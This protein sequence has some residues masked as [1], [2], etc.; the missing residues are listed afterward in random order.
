MS[1]YQRYHL[2]FW[3]EVVLYTKNNKTKSSQEVANNLS[4]SMSKTKRKKLHVKK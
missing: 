4:N 3:I 1:I 2:R